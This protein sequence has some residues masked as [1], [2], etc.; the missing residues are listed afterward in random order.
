MKTEVK[1]KNYLGINSLGRIGKLTLWNQLVTRHFDGIV[2]NLGRKTGKKIE[3]LVQALGTDSTYGDLGNFL[4]GQKSRRNIIT[5]VDP[6]QFLFD[7]DGMPV[8]ILTEERNPASIPWKKEQ[9]QIVVDCTGQFVDPTVPADNPKGS[10]RG[11]LVGGAQKVIVSA[12]FKIK[13]AGKKMP[14]DS[15]MM[16]YGINHLEYDPQRHHVISAASCTTTGLSHMIKPLMEDRF[17][18]KI[19][20]A[21][22]S[23]VHAATKTQSVLDALPKA[24]ASD[25]RKTRSVFNNIILSTTGAAKALESIIPQIQEIGFMADSVRIPTST[26]SLITLNITFNSG[27]DEKGN[28]IINQ[29]HINQIYKNAAEGPQKGL[30]VFSEKQNVSTD[31]LGY[32]AAIVIEGHESH[33]RTGFIRLPAETMKTFGIKNPVDVNIPVT[34]AKIFGW[35]DNEFG[36]YVNLL[37]KLTAYVDQYLR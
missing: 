20:T 24:G 29:K 26:V 5:V 31:L 15:I 11:H 18:S 7:I 21:S 25:L 1:S 12:P 9:V 3:D 19:L 37:E 8:K 28:P 30:L 32:K 10:L 4:Y 27:L 36:S 33:T 6:E 34:H 17:T 22:M 16:V 23:T 14:E 2:I 13:E 35:Y